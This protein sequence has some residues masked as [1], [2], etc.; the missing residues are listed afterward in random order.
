MPDAPWY[1]LT[2]QWLGFMGQGCIVYF[3]HIQEII[4]LANNNDDIGPTDMT[5][6]QSINA[7]DIQVQIIPRRFLLCLIGS[8]ERRDMY[9]MIER[10]RLKWWIS[11][12]P[13]P[14]HRTS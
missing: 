8:H 6:Q 1:M 14:D 4:D 13:P 12:M 10:V 9:R 2:L 5:Q 11:P 7:F 3:Y